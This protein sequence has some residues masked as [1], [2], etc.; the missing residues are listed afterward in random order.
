MSRPP[1]LLLTVDVAIINTGAR[2]TG[3]K[4]HDFFGPPNP[5]HKWL[6]A[7]ILS[8][9]IRHSS[10]NPPERTL[11][12]D[13]GLRKDWR[14]LSPEIVSTLQAEG[15]T[16]HA[17]TDVHSILRDS[18]SGLP[19]IEAIIWSHAHFDHTGDPSLFPPSTKLIVGPGS[20]EHLFPGYPSNPCST[21]L[22]SDYHGREVE[23]LDFDPSSRGSKTLRIG[24]FEAIDYFGDGSFY[25]LNAPGHAVGHI[26]GLAR[27][28]CSREGKTGWRSRFILM[29]GDAVHHVGELRPSLRVPL[30]TEGEQSVRTRPFYTP[31]A[32]AG[33]RWHA[34]A[35][36]GERTLRRMQEADGRDE[37][38]IVAA[39]D[40][41]VLG[42]VDVFPEFVGDFVAEGWV[43]K[44]KWR[45]L[46]DCLGPELTEKSQGTSTR[47]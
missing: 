29:A 16:L 20:R 47:T 43:D 27:V 6:A 42:V 8:F 5:N 28:G 40:E 44:V 32:A 2:L 3:I 45:F 36:E 39:H 26:C 35:E 41:T 15:W 18:T 37:I 17:P 46:R 7:P 13:L 19:P 4:A 22:E 33:R 23:E 1:P 9:L 30:A 38:L 11:L 10:P 31:V 34:D 21:I 14:N 24:Q 25:L 12:F